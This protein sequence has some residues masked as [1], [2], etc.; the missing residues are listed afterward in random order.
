MNPVKLFTNFRDLPRESFLDGDFQRCA[1]RMDEAL[2][3]F[4]WLK[5]TLPV[6]PPHDHPFDQLAMVFEG[7]M[8]L[9]VGGTPYVLKPGD[10]LRIP[11][12]IPHFARIL[13]EETCLNIDVFAPAREDYL[14]FIGNPESEYPRPPKQ[15][16]NT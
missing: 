1:V 7:V 13:S 15:Q 14:Y 10:V 11:A 2:V 4:N 5:S 12:G 6:P 8:E 9:T 16:G 3:V